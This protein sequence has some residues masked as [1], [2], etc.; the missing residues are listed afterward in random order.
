MSLE[1]KKP[2]RDSCLNRRVEWI[3][4]RTLMPDFFEKHLDRGEP[5]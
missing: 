3:A 2:G 4:K 1:F 5:R